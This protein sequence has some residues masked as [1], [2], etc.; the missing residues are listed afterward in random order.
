MATGTWSE[1]QKP[2]MPG[3]YNRFMWTAE[4]RLAQGTNGVVAM[5]VK[6]DWGPV[7][8]VTSITSISELTS[9]FGSNMDLTAYRLGRLVLLGKPKELLLYRLT[10]G[11][12]KSA[13]LTLKDT[14]ANTPV[15]V[16]NLETLYPTDRKFN[17]SIKPDIVDNTVTVITLYEGTEQLYA[18]KVQGIIDD[19]VNKI[20][21]NYNNVWIKASKLADGNGTLANIVN[22]QLTGGNNG[23]TA[24]TNQHYIDAMTTFEGYKK[25]AFTLDGVGDTSLQMAVQAW[26]DK[27]KLNGV[28][29]LGYVGASAESLIDDINSQSQ[30]FNDEA[31]TNVGV[32]GIY[33][34]V[35]YSPAE[36]ACYIAGLATGK[37]INESI[38]NEE[39]IFED[40]EPKLSK[41]EVNACLAAGTLVFVNEDQNVIVVDDINTLKNYN[42]EQSKSLGYIRAVK[43][44]YAVDEDT[45]TK[46]SD[47]IGKLTNDDIGQKVVISAL[48]KY[49]ETLQNDGIISDFTV[50]IDK[51]LQ[52]NAKDDE[53]YWKWNATYVNVMKKI[54][55]TGYI[56]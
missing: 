49:F 45:S 56:Q 29:V 24:I 20:N 2:S 50:E 6:S 18:F 37:G 13:S 21:S 55:G 27:N 3:M 22:Q 51:D 39:T 40:V 52:A 16:I 15:D 23:V 36:T 54:F 10:D 32:S 19:I 34:G 28:D 12:E 42:S 26:I 5:P 53:F 9:E 1:S 31:I 48:K 47:F 11:N 8:K 38:C 43:F 30:T 44:L 35:K 46:R 33:E 17:I 25:D 14:T 41:D 4:E 7:K